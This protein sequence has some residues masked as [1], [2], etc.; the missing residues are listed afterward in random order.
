MFEIKVGDLKLMDSGSIIT[1]PDYPIQ[2]FIRDLE[3]VFSFANDGEDKPNIRI[4]SNSG[5][6]LE[7]E[8]VNFNDLVGVGNIEPMSMGRIDG[9][10][11]FM[12]F[13]VSRLKEGG[14][15]MQYSWYS[16]EIKNSKSESNG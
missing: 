10:E 1:P 5:K 7:I 12:M 3:Y 13:R 2:F 9:H 11:I 15:T 6:K 14:R 4:L 8:L 16:K